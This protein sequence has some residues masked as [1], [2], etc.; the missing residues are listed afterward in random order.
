MKREVNIGKNATSEEWQRHVE[1]MELDSWK[2]IGETKNYMKETILLF[3][4]EENSGEDQ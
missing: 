2:L 4:K 1:L 3:E